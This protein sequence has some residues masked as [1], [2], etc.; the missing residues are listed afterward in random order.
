MKRIIN[1]IL[2]LVFLTGSAF[3]QNMFVSSGS[4][5]VNDKASLTWVVGG[6]IVANVNEVSPA[7]TPEVLK[8]Q[9]I[10]LR[11]K[12]NLGDITLSVYPNP[13]AKYVNVKLNNTKLTGGYV[14]ITDLSGNRVLSE[15]VDSKNINLF[16]ESLASGMYCVSTTDKMGN[17]IGSTKIVKK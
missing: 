17:T 2:G 8:D 11:L 10:Q 9:N 1:I 15:K 5:G 7:L 16:V 4:E 12:D 14:I 13:V 3:A 6:G